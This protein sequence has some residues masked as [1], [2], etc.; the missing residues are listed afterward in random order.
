MTWRFARDDNAF[1]PP[2][3]VRPPPSSGLGNN[4]KHLAAHVK[5]IV[6]AHE[7]SDFIRARL[8][9]FL[10]ELDQASEIVLLKHHQTQNVRARGLTRAESAR[11]EA[12]EAWEQRLVLARQLAQI[13]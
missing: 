8:G 1:S 6:S 2:S 12:E 3:A 7:F 11:Q 9:V 13:P 4:S 10:A 5:S